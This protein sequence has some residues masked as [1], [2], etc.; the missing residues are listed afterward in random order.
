MLLC[1]IGTWLAISSSSFGAP[2][3]K[4][5]LKNTIEFLKLESKELYEN[6]VSALESAFLNRLFKMFYFALSA[7]LSYILFFILLSS[8]AILYMKPAMGAREAMGT[9]QNL[10]VVGRSQEG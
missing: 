6:Y 2:I 4:I 10:D 1:C 9:N 8:T 7:I 5:H 3:S